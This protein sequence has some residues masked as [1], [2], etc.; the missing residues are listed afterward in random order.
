[1]A[2]LGTRPS[3]HKRADWVLRQ[4]CQ[5]LARRFAAVPDRLILAALVD[6]PEAE[7]PAS[8]LGMAPSGPGGNLA[9]VLALHWEDPVGSRL[10]AALAHWERQY[11]SRSLQD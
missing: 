4:H 9:D 11:A 6:V 8:P 5:A 10:R 3:L 1:M 2:R 7:L